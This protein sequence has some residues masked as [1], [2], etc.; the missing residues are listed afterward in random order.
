VFCIVANPTTIKENNGERATLYTKNQSIERSK[1]YLLSI[2]H[3]NRVDNDKTEIIN[4]EN[5]NV[6]RG[7]DGAS[8]PNIIWKTLL[9]SPLLLLLPLVVP[10]ITSIPPPLLPPLLPPPPPSPP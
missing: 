2:R 5:N 1:S 8:L 4:K 6:K 10:P 7:R 3:N 9:S